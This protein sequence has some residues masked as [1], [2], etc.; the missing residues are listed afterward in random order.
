MGQG[1]QNLREYLRFTGLPAH[2]RR[3]VVY[4]EGAAYWPHLGPV[5]QALLARFDGHIAYVS[6]AADDPGV[7][8][9]HPRLN[10][11][12]IGDGYVRTL[13]FGALQADVLLMT[14][15]DL[16]T[17]HIKRSAA[18]KHYVYLHHSLVSSHMAYREGAFDHF[19]TILCAGPHHEAEIQALE[20]L[21]GQK[22]KQL[23]RHGYGRLDAIL[24]AARDD[25]RSSSRPMILVAPSWGPQGLLEA[26]A[27]ALLQVLA[28]TPW[29]VIVRPH[30][31]TVRLAPDAL[32]CV[33]GWCERAQNL[34]LETSVTGYDS[35]LRASAMVSDWSGAAFDYALGLER[36]VL[37][38]DVP[39]KMNNVHYDRVNKD[40]IEVFGRMQVGRVI[41]ADELVRLPEHLEHLLVD[42]YM[43]RETIC[44]FRAHWVFN[45]G[46]SAETAADW[47]A[48]TVHRLGAVA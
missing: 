21:S 3:L 47:L 46:R 18:T 6:S 24:A 22:P 35:L 38:I 15:P 29:D 34:R 36:P 11:Y 7:V 8:L 16:N 27:E 25:L 48:Q 41:G 1:F 19:D 9:T 23:V 5:V 31:Q 28:D 20:V 17:F 32:A 33:R 44:A 37:F 39:R 30:P 42:P 10:A 45:V 14:M 26:H 2:Q 43:Q 13:F 12:V 4:S 40:P